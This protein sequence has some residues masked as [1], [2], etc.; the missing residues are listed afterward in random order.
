ML[1]LTAGLDE[2]AA[3]SSAV[4]Q[5]TLELKPLHDAIRFILKPP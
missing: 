5:R 4:I 3:F 2:E 1:L